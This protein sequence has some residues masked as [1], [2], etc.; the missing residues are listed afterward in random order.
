M[1]LRIENG[2]WALAFKA[3]V[4]TPC[5]ITGTNQLALLGSSFCN[6]IWDLFKD[7]VGNLQIFISILDQDLI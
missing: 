3:N 1:K 7:L 5:T 6:I 2:A 4:Q